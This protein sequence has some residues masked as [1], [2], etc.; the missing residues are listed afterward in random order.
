[1]AGGCA[2]GSDDNGASQRLCVC[3]HP[4]KAHLHYRR[5]T[6]CALCDCPRWSGHDTLIRLLL[7]R[8][9][10]R[11]RAWRAKTRTER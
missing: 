11:Y 5:G 6:E 7:L 1:V 2:D 4:K 8:P 10:E 9:S 3:G